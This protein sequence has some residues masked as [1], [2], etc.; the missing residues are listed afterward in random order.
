MLSSIE[1]P[2]ARCAFA[3]ERGRNRGVHRRQARHS[4]ARAPEHCHRWPRLRLVCFE[5]MFIDPLRESLVARGDFAHRQPG[6]S[7]IHGL[8]SGVNVAGCWGL[9]P[10]CEAQGRPNL[11]RVIAARNGIELSRQPEPHKPQRRGRHRFA[12]ITRH[13]PGDVTADVVNMDTG[14]MRRFRFT[15]NGDGELEIEEL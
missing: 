3:T 6:F 12:S 15:K 2:C 14:L 4:G 8:G 9:L 13:A 11:A 1:L 5:R 10:A 7:V